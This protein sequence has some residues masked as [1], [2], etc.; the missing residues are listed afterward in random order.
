[1]GMNTTDATSAEGSVKYHLVEAEEVSHKVLTTRATKPKR[2]SKFNWS[3][4]PME[5]EENAVPEGNESGAS[6]DNKVN[7]LSNMQT[8]RGHYNQ[9]SSCSGLGRRSGPRFGG[10][11]QYGDNQGSFY[12]GVYV[13]IPDVKLTAQW[14]KSQM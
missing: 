13:P 8:R 1:M 2:K 7:K 4:F 14:A 10:R 6:V 11:R 5:G 3:Q 12:N 9:Q